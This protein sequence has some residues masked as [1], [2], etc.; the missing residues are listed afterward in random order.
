MM[1]MMLGLLGC[2]D[3]ATGMKRR[4]M[5]GRKEGEVEVI[6][7]G[8]EL[9]LFVMINFLGVQKVDCWGNECGMKQRLH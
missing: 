7:E 5:E 4:R 9:G 8:C 1:M 3:G 2:A 6:H